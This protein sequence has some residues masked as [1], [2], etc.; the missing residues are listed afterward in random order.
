PP[1]LRDALPISPVRR[2]LTFVADTAG[3]LMMPQPVILAPQSPVAEALA[4]CRNPDL[5]AALA[6]LVF[7][8]RSPTATPT[9]QYLGCVHIQSLLRE[10][11]STMVAEAMDSD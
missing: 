10:L 8:V 9:G 4:H 1:A 3:G 6:S 11:P 2:L 7:V 5:S